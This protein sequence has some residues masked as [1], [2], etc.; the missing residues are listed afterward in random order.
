M[1]TYELQPSENPQPA[2]DKTLAALDRA[3]ARLEAINPDLGAERRELVQVERVREE[4]AARQALT[5]IRIC[6]DV[7]L[8]AA[9]QR[10]M[11]LLEDAR[12][13]AAE[14]GVAHLTAETLDETM[15]VV[16]ALRAASPASHMRQQFIT[17]VL[18]RKELWSATRLVLPSSASRRPPT[19]SG[20]PK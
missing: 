11:V 18:P 10:L 17:N 20:M 13:E 19:P 14:R 7:A 1:E 9:E 15:R 8:V 3:L 16:T 6:T 4:G 5:T 12:C 2:T